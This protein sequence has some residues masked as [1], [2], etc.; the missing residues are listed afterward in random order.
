MRN[1]KSFIIS[2]IL[3]IFG[4][5]V[6]GCVAGNGNYGKLVYDNDVKEKFE[7]FQFYHQYKYYYYGSKTLP[8]AFL[9]ID[10]DIELKSSLWRPI[11]LTP[12]ILLDWIRIQANRKEGNLGRFGSVMLDANGKQIGVYYSLRSW[13]QWTMI[14]IVG[15]KE[16]KVASPSDP[17]PGRFNPRTG[18]IKL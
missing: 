9:G 3:I 5:M 17:S 7:D 16:I 8:E 12:E 15:E 18:G 2:I 1:Y 13:E 14:R 4:L 10:E 6:T 11:E